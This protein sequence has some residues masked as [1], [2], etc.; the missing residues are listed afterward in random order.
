M[1]LEGTVGGSD[2]QDLPGCRAVGR[3]HGDPDAADHDDHLLQLPVGA[4]NSGREIR[5][6]DSD[7]HDELPA[8]RPRPEHRDRRHR[9]NRI[10]T[11]H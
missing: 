2:L 1:R 9:P 3:Q 4:E 11:E 6:S 10:N 5:R 8:R 7:H